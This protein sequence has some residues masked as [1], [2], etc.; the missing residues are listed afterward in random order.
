MIKLMVDAEVQPQF[1]Y[2]SFTRLTRRR[3]NWVRIEAELDAGLYFSSD[4]MLGNARPIQ[5]ER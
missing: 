4:S 5:S 1:G 2:H 3:F